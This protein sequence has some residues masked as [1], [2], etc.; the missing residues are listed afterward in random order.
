[1]K[2]TTTTINGTTYEITINR[3]FYSADV[4]DTTTGRMYSIDCSDATDED[5]TDEENIQWALED[6]IDWC[7]WHS[8]HETHEI[9]DGEIWRCL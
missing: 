2:A 4:T 7:E 3:N 6:A 8:S 9:K 5:A 1:M